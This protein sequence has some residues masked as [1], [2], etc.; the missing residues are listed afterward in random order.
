MLVYLAHV[1]PGDHD[2]VHWCP[3]CGAVSWRR[4]GAGARA[5]WVL[6]TGTGALPSPLKPHRK[7]AGTRR[8]A[9]ER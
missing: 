8:A 3:A 1:G 4:Y 6:P 9:T 2:A 5:R 7:R